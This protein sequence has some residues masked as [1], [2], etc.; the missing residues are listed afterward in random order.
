MHT[1]NV[2]SVKITAVIESA[3]KTSPRFLFRRTNKEDVLAIADD[4]PWLLP[5]FV[6]EEGYLLMKT[7]C[8]IIDTGDVRIAVEPPASATTRSGRTPG[9]TTCRRTSSTSSSPPA[10]TPRP[11][12]TWCA[13]ISTSTTSAGTPNSSTGTGCPRSPTPATCWCSESWSTGRARDR[14]RAR[15]CSAIRWLR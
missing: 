5:H 7:Q 1:W 2:G 15:T 11:S 9:G 10:T 14:R 8:L 4:A 13:L 12:T 3:D 6:D